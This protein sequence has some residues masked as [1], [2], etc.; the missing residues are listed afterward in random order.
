MPVIELPPAPEPQ[1]LTTP[2]APTVTLANGQRLS[3]EG[4]STEEL[5]WLQWEQEQRFAQQMLALPK[6]SDERAQTIGQAYDT[7]CTILA[8]QQAGE[9]PL[10]MGLDRRY[11]RLVLELLN[12]QIRRGIGQPRLFEIGYGSGM[13]LKKVSDQGFRVSGIEVSSAMHDEALGVLGE[14]FADQLLLG[15]L[16]SID[17]QS[18]ADRPSLVYWNDVFEH[19]CP[20]EIA[21]YLQQI[22]QLLI[23]GG[24]L[25][26]ITPHWLLRPSDVTGDFCPLRTEARGLHLKEYR[27][28]EV[29]RLLKQSGFRHVATPLA[30][31]RQRIYLAGGGLRLP[32]QLCE[33]LIDRLPVRYAHLLCRGA[34]MSFTIATK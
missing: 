18:L 27:L 8:A 20:D 15:D 24:A 19:I 23:P 10:E 21:D 29:S 7:I 30:V 25:V 31:S 14:G 1:Q 12:Q 9:G 17:K 34:G 16:R 22:H 33:G 26:T 13:L 6:G 2:P 11:I 32:K 28:A 4:L 5:H 3:L